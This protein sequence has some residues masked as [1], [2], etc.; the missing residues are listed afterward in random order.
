MDTLLTVDD[1]SS[2]LKCGRDKAYRLMRT[3]GF[4]AIKIGKRRY[5]KQ[6]IFNNWLETYTYKEFKI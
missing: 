2:I 6:S 5:V 3:P 4:P 1:I